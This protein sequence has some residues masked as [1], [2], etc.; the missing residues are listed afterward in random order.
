MYTAPCGKRLRNISEVT[1][2]LS[3]CQ[4]D[5]GIDCFNFDPWIRIL[6]EFVTDKNFINVPDITQE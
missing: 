6:D 1:S 2:Y 4:N 5:L 3:A